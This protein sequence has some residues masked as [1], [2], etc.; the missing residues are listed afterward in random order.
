MS[1]AVVTDISGTW[2]DRGRKC[3]EYKLSIIPDSSAI[4]YVEILNG[5]QTIRWNIISA[6]KL[7]IDIFKIVSK[8]KDGALIEDNFKLLNA[9]E[10]QLYKK[11]AL[12]P[13]KKFI[14]LDSKWFDDETPT[15]VM[16]RCP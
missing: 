9:N 14:A 11:I 1:Q 4:G 16:V 3:S 7:D 12:S 13:N 8:A 2:T 6:D 15:P 10:M 5:Q